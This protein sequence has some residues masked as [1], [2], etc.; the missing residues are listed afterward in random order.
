MHSRRGPPHH[1]IPSSLF[2]TD[3]IMLSNR[4]FEKRPYHLFAAFFY[5][6][7]LQ[8]QHNLISPKQVVWPLLSE[9]HLGCKAQGAKAWTSIS[10]TV[11]RLISFTLCLFQFFFAMQSHSLCELERR[12][13]EGALERIRN[14][15][16]EQ[17]IS[18][19]L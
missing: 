13:K 8:R 5:A 11:R 12:C 15:L 10:K 14:K 18:F 16:N 17:V 1:F 9:M 2:R 6:A 3:E 7:K 4:R 19:T